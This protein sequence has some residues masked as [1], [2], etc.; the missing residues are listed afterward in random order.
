M[1]RLQPYAQLVRLPNLP[2]AVADILLGVL[3]TGALVEPGRWPVYLL[4]MPASACLYCGG[5][6]WNDFFDRE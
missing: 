3:A 2:T 6:V 5:M 1:N 4:L